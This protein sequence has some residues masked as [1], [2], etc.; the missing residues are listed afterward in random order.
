M[1]LVYHLQSGSSKWSPTSLKV[2]SSLKFVR[3]ILQEKTGL[4]NDQT[5]SDGGKASTGNIARD[6]SAIKI[7]SFI[8]LQ[9]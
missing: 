9:L 5:S 8:G 7:I 6:F 1:T 3:G 4:K 2:Q